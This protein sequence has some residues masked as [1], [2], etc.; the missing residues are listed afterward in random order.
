M[1]TDGRCDRSARCVAGCL[2]LAQEYCTRSEPF[3][4]RE[5]TVF[6]YGTKERLGKFDEKTA[7]ITRLAVGCDRTTM[8]QSGKCLNRC[9]NNPVTRQV[10]DLSCAPQRSPKGDPQKSCIE[11]A[12][13][14]ANSIL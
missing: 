10:V 5:P 12:Q 14:A 2:V 6:A 11:L 9:F 7:T 8:C 1:F 13:S 3:V 4:K